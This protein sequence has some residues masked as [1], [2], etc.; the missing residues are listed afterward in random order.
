[1]I[2]EDGREGDVFSL[3]GP[4]VYGC[5]GSFVSNLQ[6][7]L[8]SSS[9]TNATRMDEKTGPLEMEREKQI[10]QSDQRSC[11]YLLLFKNV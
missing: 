9:N 1:M 3:V 11:C 6:C 5:L 10:S 7:T 2:R 8:S 4:K